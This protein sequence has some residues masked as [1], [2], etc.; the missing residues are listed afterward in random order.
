MTD[1]VMTQSNSNNNDSDNNT[2]STE[3]K[4]ILSKL[5]SKEYSDVKYVINLANNNELRDY[6]DLFNSQ[7]FYTVLRNLYYDSVVQYDIIINNND[8]NTNNIT[9]IHD[10]YDELKSICTLL[11]TILNFI[12]FNI[13]L[14]KNN[15]FDETFVNKLLSRLYNKHNTKNNILSNKFSDIPQGILATVGIFNQSN[16]HNN[17]NSMPNEYVLI[18]DLAYNIYNKCIYIR[19]HIRYIL[20]QICNNYIKSHDI[21]NNNG[22]PDA[23]ALYSSFVNGL[24]Y[25]PLKLSYLQYYNNIILPLHHIDIQQLTYIHEKLVYCIISY[26]KQQY[27]L[28]YNV[29]DII[30]NL[31]YFTQQTTQKSVLYLHELDTLLDYINIDEFNKIQHTF[32]Q[33]I[34]Y[35]LTSIQFQIAEKTCFLFQNKHLINIIKQ[36]NNI[37]IDSLLHIL[38]NDK[39]WN[40]TVRKL[41]INILYV[42]YTNNQSYFEPKFHTLIN[43]TNI[44]YTKQVIN[45]LF[46]HQT[47]NELLNIDKVKQQII[48]QLQNNKDNTIQYTQLIF[49]EIIAKGSFSTVQKCKLFIKGYSQSYWP[50]FATKIINKS[51]IESNIQYKL[52]YEREINILTNYKHDHIIKLYGQ[53]SNNINIY[54]LLEYSSI[55]DLHSVIIKNGSLSLDNTI[56]IIAELLNV[57]EYLHNNNIIYCDLKPE[58]IIFNERNHIKLIDFGSCQY[59]DKVSKDTPIEGTTEYLAPEVLLGSHSVSSSSDIWSLGCI[60]YQMLTGKP[61]IFIDDDDVIYHEK[62]RIDNSDILFDDDE[63]VDFGFD[64]SKIDN[65]GNNIHQ[66]KQ[67]QHDKKHID[68][69]NKLK[70]KFKSF[71]TIT[72]DMLPHN[73]PEQVK[74]ILMKILVADPTKRATIQ[75]L[76]QESIFQNIDFNNLYNTEIPTISAGSVKSS[77]LDS[78]WQ[79]RKNSILWAPSIPKY[80]FNDLQW[81]LEPITEA[82]DDSETENTKSITGT[83]SSSRRYKTTKASNLL[84]NNTAMTGI[85]ETE[86]E[87]QD[88]DHSDSESDS[89]NNMQPSSK[90]FNMLRKN[91]PLSSHASTTQQSNTLLSSNI[92]LPPKPTGLPSSRKMGSG[93]T[94]SNKL[95]Q[96]ILSNKPVS[97]SNNDNNN[98]P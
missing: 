88:N 54:L 13:E 15:L 91:K 36:Y 50:E 58:N 25:K 87:K 24:Q 81:I 53:T 59:S 39:H 31:K 55:G 86:E 49:S 95:L 16:K 32:I 96:R 70:T 56:Y 40:E 42:L 18:R 68:A 52:N 3:S 90:L 93:N 75:Q 26:I 12:E 21:C 29:L 71:T 19:L 98:T 37:F 17:H 82:D 80:E 85:D 5:Q 60:W 83:T 51:I 43:S 33:F 97:N 9:T 2:L 28:I 38:Y 84:N 72:D 61:F 27:N 64:S 11:I 94:T 89:D 65:N 45:D 79:R 1:T 62:E 77:Q 67:Q 78:K 57:L 47:T 20:Y 92:T 30:L 14:S 63:S 41:K 7:Q 23:I 4:D 34:Q 6:D 48:D 73:F 22:I 74:P 35:G 8:K 44:E 76:K 46:A 10:K 66:Q 69:Y